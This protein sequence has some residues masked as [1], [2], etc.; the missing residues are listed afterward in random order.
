MP[1]NAAAGAVLSSK[2]I[3]RWPKLKARSGEKRSHAAAKGD[4]TDPHGSVDGWVLEWWEN[5]EAVQ[6]GEVRRSFFFFLF[7]VLVG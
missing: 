4:G 7:V 2:T 1:K 5:G 6:W 3:G